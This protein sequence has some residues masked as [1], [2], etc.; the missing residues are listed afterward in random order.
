[1]PRIRSCIPMAVAMM[2]AACASDFGAVNL[3]GGVNAPPPQ[4]EAVGDA[5][6]TNTVWRWEGTQKSDGTSVVP[7]SAANYTLEFQPGGKLNVRIDCNRGGGQYLLNGNNLTLGSIA[8]TKMLCPQA[9][10]DAEFARELAA[11]TTQ[12]FEGSE[13]VLSLAGNGGT[14]RFAGPR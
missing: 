8:L 13:L 9:S 10:L 12:R 2:L 3:P 7:L 11:V 14:M 5:S 1:M 6:L 4:I